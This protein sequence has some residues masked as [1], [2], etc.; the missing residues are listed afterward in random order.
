MCYFYYQYFLVNG[1]NNVRSKQYQV[2]V[3]RTAVVLSTTVFDKVCLTDQPSKYVTGTYV[4]SRSGRYRDCL[5]VS[6]TSSLTDMHE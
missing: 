6:F 2:G 4:V 3:S 5:V 1:Y